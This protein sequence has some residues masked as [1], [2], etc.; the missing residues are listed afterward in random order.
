M[1]EL[2]STDRFIVTANNY[3][4]DLDH[5]VLSL[6]YLPIIGSNAYT[7]YEFLYRIMDEKLM[8]EELLHKRIIDILNIKIND[9]EK[10]RES[11]EGVCLIRTYVKEGLLIYELKK[12]LTPKSF[13]QSLLGVYLERLL[14]RDNI[15]ILK[16]LFEIK[17]FSNKGIKEITKSFDQVYGNITITENNDMFEYPDE[18]KSAS[19]LELQ[20]T[21]FD[22]RLFLETIDANDQTFKKEEK[23]LVTNLAYIY[24]LDPLTMA[25]A[26]FESLD[27]SRKISE[28]VLKKNVRRW[29]SYLKEQVVIIKDSKPTLERT[30]YLNSLDQISYFKTV[31]PKELLYTLSNGF[32]SQAD[33]RIVE[34]LN[35]EI[36]LPLE[37][38][39]VLLTYVFINKDGK[40]PTYNYFE[41]VAMSW[42]NDG[43]DTAEKAMAFIDRNQKAHD[44]KKAYKELKNYNKDNKENKDE[45]KVSWLDDYL[46]SINEE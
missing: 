8:T 36:K 25:K 29:N 19:Y 24:D 27:D 43:I 30:K 37:V 23:E 10:A 11:L 22:F 18:I 32:V 42:I 31:T 39:N 9:V 5:R 28:E 13:F 1:G 4:S 14:S 15:T 35:L 2:R 45:I 3:L 7:L 16:K 34:R 12:P 21:R 33:L 6:L 40:M 20:N 46:K 26:Y 17:G 41:K 38:I 44:E